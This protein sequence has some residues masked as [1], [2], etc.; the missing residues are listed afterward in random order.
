MHIFIYCHTVPL[1]HARTLTS[2][3]SQKKIL[4]YGLP[5][6]LFSYSSWEIIPLELYDTSWKYH[7]FTQIFSHCIR[8]ERKILSLALTVSKVEVILYEFVS[9]IFH[10][11]T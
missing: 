9:C 1:L 8:Q 11:D 10:V 5:V 2:K 7:I 6:N 4:F 3:V